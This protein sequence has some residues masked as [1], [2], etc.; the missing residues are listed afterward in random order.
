FAPLAPLNSTSI[1]NGGLEGMTPFTL[2]GMLE[3]ENAACSEKTG[4]VAK[5]GVGG[6]TTGYLANLRFNTSRSSGP[7]RSDHSTATRRNQVASVRRLQY[8]ENP[9]FPMQ[10]AF[11]FP[12]AETPVPWSLFGGKRRRMDSETRLVWRAQCES[13][14]GSGD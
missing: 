3:R 9:Y 8:L 13:A 1:P 2:R 7:G 4:G 6:V 10:P 5:G 11:L 14:F 12:L